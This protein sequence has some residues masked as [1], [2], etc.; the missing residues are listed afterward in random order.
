MEN[1]SIKISKLTENAKD[2]LV[3]SYNFAKDTKSS[4][5]KPE[6]LFISLLSLNQGLSARFLRSL[7]I[8]IEKTIESIKL[9]MQLG[10]RM[11][12][13]IKVSERVKG[14]IKTSFI[15]AR[16][17]SHVYV[18]TEHI[19]LS[20]LKQK[21]LSFVKELA[22]AGLDYSSVRDKLF[23]YATYV[24]GVF[25]KEKGEVVR[26]DDAIKYFGRSINEL[27]KKGKLMPIIGREKEVNRMIRILLRQTK[28]NPILVGEAGVGKTAV[29]EGLVQRIVKG[30]VP[31]SVKSLE[32]FQIDI[33]SIVAGSK[34]RG[35]IEQ[36]L[37]VLMSEV[38]SSPN[39]VLFIDEI[40]MIIGAG[41]TGADRT[42]DIANIL[43]PRLT[44]GSIRVIGATTVDEYRRYFEEDSALSRR[45]QPVK[46][47]EITEKD[48]IRILKGI[49]PRLEE[50]HGVK[51][52]NTALI[53]AS[54][55]SN[56]YI[57]DRYL[58]DKAIDVL[59]EASALEKLKKE[60]EYQE[61]MTKRDKLI[62]IIEK[63]DA[64]INKNLFEKALAFKKQERDVKDDLKQKNKEKKLLL[65]SGKFMVTDEDIKNVISEWTGIPINTLSAGEMKALRGLNLKLGRRIMGQKDAVQRVSAAL[66][67]ARVGISDDRRPLASFLFLGPTGVGKTEMAKVIAE[68]FFGTSKALIQMD[69]SEFMEQ[70]SVAK[71]IGSPPGYVGYQEG[72]QLTEKVKKRPYSVVLFDEIEK[73]HPDM[74]NALLQILEEG[75]MTDGKGRKVD[76]KNTIIVL[77]SNIGAEDI[78]RDKV[79][80]FKIDTE[81]KN[82]DEAYERMRERL[83]E[84]LKKVLR[85]EFINRIDE[86]VIFRGLDESDAVRITRLILKDVQRRLDERDINLIISDLAVRLIASKGF[87]D[88][89]GARNLRRKVQ[90]MVENPLSDLLIESSKEPS[91]VK[92]SKSGKMLKMI[93]S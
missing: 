34:V 91:K 3:K 35:D 69:M 20:F 59:D 73:A 14:I 2:V 26:E 9:K 72:G 43:K 10:K 17:F 80:G 47:E 71:I 92:I 60:E 56:R 42:M 46:V 83:T 55:L 40:H 1:K 32:V 37:L 30:K 12:R 65:E 75:H 41:A 23:T 81:G 62:E 53:S 16:D 29:V 86:V 19:L 21:D 44:D 7:G 28:N 49:K 74:L 13:S 76:F 84:E 68:E 15:L 78:S 38:A 50:Y 58:P 61:D 33:A 63:K 8:D 77:T 90:E 67:R 22:E 18:G 31:G 57:T 89:Y 25:I 24:P 87:S 39:K 88:E 70:H 36:R 45:F 66:K 82:V 11:P 52:M 93:P 85:P 51:I 4:E 79:L 5:I 54:K 64:A 6:H 27:A 48:T